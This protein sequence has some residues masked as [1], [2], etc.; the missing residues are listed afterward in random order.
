MQL[1]RSRLHSQIL[2]P[3]RKGTGET[4]VILKAKKLPLYTELLVG[5]CSWSRRCGPMQ[6]CPRMV[7][8][9]NKG[10]SSNKRKRSEIQV[11]S[12]SNCTPTV[13]HP[14]CWL[15]LARARCWVSY[16]LPLKALTEVSRSGGIS[17]CECHL[18]KYCLG[19]R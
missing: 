6:H 19:K 12:A 2:T 14:K 9:Q 16:A 3:Q 10:L 15:R 4:K 13:M 5:L 18:G 17:I 11:A 1:E 8:S 7:N